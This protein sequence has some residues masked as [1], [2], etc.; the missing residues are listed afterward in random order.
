MFPW[1]LKH[2]IIAP[3]F[4][5]FS[6]KV[7]KHNT[8]DDRR[9]RM[10]SDVSA[11]SSSSHQS[12]K[13]CRG[14]TKETIRR[15]HH[16]ENSSTLHLT[17]GD[18]KVGEESLNGLQGPISGSM[19]SPQCPVPTGVGESDHNWRVGRAHLSVSPGA[20]TGV[21]RMDVLPTGANGRGKGRTKTR[22]GDSTRA[23]GIRGDDSRLDIGV[24]GKGRASSGSLAGGK[25]P[26]IRG[27]RGLTTA[28]LLK[29]V[30]R[31]SPPTQIPHY[32]MLIQTVR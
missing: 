5:S 16:S 30:R 20:N 11:S 24:D 12:Y 7:G 25:E 26:P 17:Y 2:T 15:R 19:V 6:P 10:S 28:T 14:G 29:L 4:V 18:T 32:V 23:P 27:L 9:S 21:S 22:R 13:L 1:I 8:K 31:Y 3:P